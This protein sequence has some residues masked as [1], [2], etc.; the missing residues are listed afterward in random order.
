MSLEKLL[1][2][3]TPPSNEAEAVKHAE[4]LSRFS[5]LEE[6]RKGNWIMLYGSTF[7]RGS[8]MLH[9]VLVPSAELKKADPED[10]THWSG[11][12][13]DSW[14]CGLV[15]GGGEPPRVELSPPLLNVGSKAVKNYRQ[16]VFGRSFNGRTEDRRYFEIAP[17]LTQA[18]GLHWTPERHAWCRFDGNGDIEDV[19]V[20]TEEEGRGGYGTAVC[21]AVKREVMEMH[22]A[23][24][25]TVLL[26]MFD[27][28]VMPK[29]FDGWDS[30][31]RRTER[32][33]E[34]DLYYHSGV[35]G[36]SSFFRGV[37]I[38]RPKRNSKQYG[39]YLYAQ[40]RQPRRYESFITHDF[41]NKQ[42]AMVSC[43]PDAMASYFQK[44]SPLPFQ[45]SP[46]FFSTQ[47]F[48]TNTRLTR[49]STRSNIGRLTVAIPGT[50]SPTT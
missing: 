13:Y 5:L 8:A 49:R 6:E 3:V 23:A 15:S 48:W 36:S 10:L 40:E 25:R 4:Q 44:D 32:D 42:I 1:Q 29:D 47:L 20:W 21:I 22:M 30:N 34:Q 33:E 41:K 43:S 16:L 19:I 45:T 50:C 37:Q 7:N 31:K 27:S 17:E 12:P 11:N 39:A 9:S 26:Q 28:T 18:H 2:L 14:G 46:V 38:I 35:G 24:T